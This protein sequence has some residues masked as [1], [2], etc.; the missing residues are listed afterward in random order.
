ML[1]ANVLLAM[2]WAALTGH[3]TLLNLTLGF[4]IGYVILYLATRTVGPTGYFS[5]VRDVIRFAFFFIWEV[6]KANLRV[7]YYVMAPADRM[8]P[9]ILAVPLDLR[10]DV[11]IT[12][13][14]NVITLTPGTLSLDVSTDRRVLYVHAIWIEDTSSFRQAVKSGLERR[15]QEV[16]R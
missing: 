16:F 13:L 3:F 9:G 6:L 15:I 1:L 14:A 10:R 5:Q 12:M 11:E 8:R 2:A 7:A 4:A